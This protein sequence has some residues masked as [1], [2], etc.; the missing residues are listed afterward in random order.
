MR[1]LLVNILIFVFCACFI[2]LSDNDIS[3]RYF[4]QKFTSFIRLRAGS[5]E[6]RLML[7][8]I[9]DL[10]EKIKELEEQLRGYL[11]FWSGNCTEDYNGRNL[12]K[13]CKK[14][15][16]EISKIRAELEQLKSQLKELQES[17]LGSSYDTRL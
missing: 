16:E 11:L 17:F 6:P 7:L 2:T 4:N 8:K 12:R 9:K 1:K 10:K 15:K 13:R 3:P 14:T 5:N